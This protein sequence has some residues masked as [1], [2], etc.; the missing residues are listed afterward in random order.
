MLSQNSELPKPRIGII[1]GGVGGATIALKLSEQGADVVLFEKETSLVNGPPMCHLHAGG[2]LYREISDQQCID[3]LKQS[4]NT[5]R[6]YRDAIDYR[7]T[8]VAVPVDDNGQ[9]EDVIARLNIL[10][11]EYKQLI[12]D[13]PLN[14]VL[15][16]ADE[17]FTLYD[18][19]A[20]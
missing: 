4:I 20:T 10:Q 12:A 13:D 17:Y 19:Q 6:L 11:K 1:G 15:G 14:Q 5:A 3:L 2:N 9:P 16:P 18:R 7:P 8:V